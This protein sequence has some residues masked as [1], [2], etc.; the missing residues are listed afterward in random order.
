MIEVIDKIIDNDKVQQIFN[1]IQS[2]LPVLIS[3]FKSLVNI[4]VLIFEFFIDLVRK[5][6]ELF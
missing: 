3:A 4:F 6:I 5:A 2:S 1:A